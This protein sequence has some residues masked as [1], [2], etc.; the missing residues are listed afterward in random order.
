MK[1]VAKP[2]IVSSSEQLLHIWPTAHIKV[3]RK[4]WDMVSPSTPLPAWWPTI[5]RKLPSPAAA[6]EV[7]GVNPKLGTPPVK[8]CIWELSP[9]TSTFESQWNCKT[10]QAHDG[11]N[12]FWRAAWIW[13]P[14]WGLAR[15]QQLK[16]AQT[17]CERGLFISKHHQPEGPTSNLT[18]S[19]GLAAGRSRLCS[20][21]LVPAGQYLLERNLSTY[22]VPWCLQLLPGDSSRPPGFGGQW[23]SH[24]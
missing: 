7:K 1:S 15:G 6:W 5:G 21:C 16:R 24:L 11:R 13:S 18:L 3:D 12:R 14:S 4:G 19:R 10:H 22:L 23:G 20:L 8:T 2:G 9:Q 17:F